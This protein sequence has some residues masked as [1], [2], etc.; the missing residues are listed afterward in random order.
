MPCRAGA[1]RAAECTCLPQ[2]RSS[3]CTARTKGLR[4]DMKAALDKIDQ[5]YLNEIVEGQ[6]AGNSNSDQ[7]TRSSREDVHV[8]PVGI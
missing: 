1:V 5:H 7:R 2:D 6:G 3:A 4:N 8:P